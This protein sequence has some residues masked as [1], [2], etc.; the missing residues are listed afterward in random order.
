MNL[1][2]QSARHNIALVG[3]TAL[4]KE[5]PERWQAVGN[6]V[7]DLTG[8]RDELQI[9]SSKCESVTARQML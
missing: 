9:S 2:G 5:I 3:N 8:W 4:F 7:S 6:I 1:R